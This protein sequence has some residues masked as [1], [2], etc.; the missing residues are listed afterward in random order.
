MRFRNKVFLS[1]FATC[2]VLLMALAWSV[3]ELLHQAVETQYLEHYGSLSQVIGDTLR[4]MEAATARISGGS[5]QT[6][7][8]ITSRGKIPSEE[9]LKKIRTGLQISQLVITAK[10]GTFLRDTET[11]PAL[12][13]AKI[14]DFCAG[15]R[16]LLDDPGRIETTP[17]LPSFPSGQAYMFSMMANS[18]QTGL[19]EAGVHVSFI[20]DTL[21][22]ALRS[23]RNLLSVGLYTPKGVPLGVIEQGAGASTTPQPLTDLTVGSRMA[24]RERLSI[25]TKVPA[26]VEQCCECSQKKLTQDDGKYYYLLRTN[27]TLAPLYASLALLRQRALLILAVALLF[28]LAFS[29]W[30]SALLVRR[31]NEFRS[32]VREIVET[33]DLS[34]RLAFTGGD[35]ITDL[36]A[37]FDELTAK[38][39]RTQKSAIQA[40]KN[41]ALAAVAKQVA[42]DI[43]SPLAALKAVAQQIPV[44]SDGDRKLLRAAAGRIHEIAEGLLARYR[45]NGPAPERAAGAVDESLLQVAEGALEEKRAELGPE[46]RVALEFRADAGAYALF[47]RVPPSELKRVISNLLNNAVEA[48]DGAGHA[49]VSVRADGDAAVLAV[50][51]DGKGIPEDLLPKLMEPGA[52]HGKEFGT[53]LGLAHARETAQAHGGEIRIRS[54]AGRGT[55]VEIRL[56]RSE[57][58]AWYLRELVCS[59]GTAVVVVD[60][61]QSIHRVWQS[62]F[63][64]AEGAH[65]TLVHCFGT[66]ELAAQA[67]RP[68]SRLFLVDHEISGSRESGL[69]AIVR[70]GILSESVLVTSHAD[71]SQLLARCGELGIRLLP[72]SLAGRVPIRA[73]T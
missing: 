23:D 26:L 16:R 31:L 44:A 2:A 47:T 58:P 4:Q 33:G 32:G 39:D 15:Y 55:R 59:P 18:T 3:E 70:L 34:R 41:R 50:E 11:P 8:N 24:G 12:R 6:L 71:D 14:F 67:R 72:K 56:P 66:E 5:V 7:Y 51:D 64:A 29:R 69:D 45:E 60:D 57:P 30:L 53:G 13:T 46:S 27:V 37:T 73:G 21:G 48:I 49:A 63:A 20:V 1:T 62:R 35:E 65:P 36:A 61:D 25:V 52:T 10:D 42:H 19:V 38:L 68:G 40:E 54:E 43:R 9:G 17:I 22:K 28:G